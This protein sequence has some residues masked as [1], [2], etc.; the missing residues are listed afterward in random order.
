MAASMVTMWVEMLAAN[1]AATMVVYWV[2]STVVWW[3]DLK[4]S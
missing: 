1:S 2:P 4:V 3:D